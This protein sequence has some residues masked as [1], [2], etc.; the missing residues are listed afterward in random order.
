MTVAILTKHV[1]VTHSYMRSAITSDHD[2]PDYCLFKMLSNLGLH[3]R[4]N[5]FNKWQI[6]KKLK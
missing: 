3:K 2:Q 6:E 1:N 4:I 5:N